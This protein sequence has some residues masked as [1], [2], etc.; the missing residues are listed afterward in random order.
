MKAIVIVGDYPRNIGLLKRLYDNKK[1]EICFLTLF[2]RE[3]LVP[4][5]DKNL[6]ND[7]KKL[8]NLHFEKRYLSEKKFF[9]SK[10]DFIEK[11]K[12]KI[13][14]STEDE[15][16][17]KKILAAINSSKAD[18]A[19]ITGVPILRE[20]ILSALPVNTINLHLGI[21]PYYKGAFTIFWPFYFLE[22][23][24]AGTTFHLIDKYVDTGEIIHNNIPK[25][26]KGDGI[27]DVACK[28]VLSAHADVDILVNHIIKRVE[29]K[30]KPKRDM[31]LR[32]RG[33]LYLK[34]DWKPEMLR[35][36]Y[37]FFD[38][39]IVDLYLDNKIKC[40]KPKLIKINQ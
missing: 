13:L 21:I 4:E 20:P 38:D 29:S 25:L 14:V 10:S 26:D 11:I 28:A 33:K 8:W 2:K 17:S 1:I 16:H 23:T 6:S 15:L 19:F 7:L 12:H 34:S 40:P 9:K 32:Y 30:I 18:A 22:P 5:P 31:S 36:I 35:V 24:M 39:K 3:Q 37:E 27:H